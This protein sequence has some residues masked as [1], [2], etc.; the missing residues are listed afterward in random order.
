MMDGSTE[1]AMPVLT[2]RLPRPLLARIEETAAING[3]SRSRVVQQVLMSVF[4]GSASDS[5]PAIKKREAA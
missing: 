3:V 2:V 4:Y 1:C 5:D